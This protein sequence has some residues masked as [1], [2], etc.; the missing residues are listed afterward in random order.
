[1]NG[2]LFFFSLNS[3]DINVAANEK[4]TKFKI[5]IK[6]SLAATEKSS[7]MTPHQRRLHKVAADEGSIAATLGSPLM[8]FFLFFYNLLLA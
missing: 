5:K 7:L 1:M 8:T 6:K 3:G 2:A 4:R